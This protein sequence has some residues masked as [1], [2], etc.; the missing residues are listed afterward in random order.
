MILWFQKEAAKTLCK[1]LRKC[2]P[3]DP[4]PNNKVL[5]NLRSF[6]C[7]DPSNTPVI[8]SSDFHQISAEP[9]PV[10]GEYQMLGHAF[11]VV[12]WRFSKLIFLKN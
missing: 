4:C 8:T 5:K 7:C 12:C 6:L 10:L 3:R 11:I 2:L 1:L 9:R